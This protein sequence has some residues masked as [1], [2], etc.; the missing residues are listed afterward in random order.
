MSSVGKGHWLQKECFDE[1]IAVKDKG[2]PVTLN[3]W[4]NKQIIRSR[5][6]M[7]LFLHFY[8]KLKGKKL[9]EREKIFRK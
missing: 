3:N 8:I 4:I 6:Y 7:E 9:S 1:V 2:Y 5:I